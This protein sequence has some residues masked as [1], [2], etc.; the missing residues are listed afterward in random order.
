MRPRWSDDRAGRLC[1]I[2]LSATRGEAT[3]ISAMAGFTYGIVIWG[4][5]EM[6]SSWLRH[7][8]APHPADAGADERAPSLLQAFATLA[9]HEFAILAVGVGLLVLTSGASNAVGTWTFVCCG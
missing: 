3:P 4:W 1:A 7:G 5:L 8:T 6:A 9:W 2:G